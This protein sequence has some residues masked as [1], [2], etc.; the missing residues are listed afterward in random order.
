M[1]SSSAPCGADDSRPGQGQCRRRHHA[2]VLPCAVWPPL[3]P[4]TTGQRPALAA[5][6]PPGQADA[7]QHGRFPI[8]FRAPAKGTAWIRG[9]SIRGW[10][11]QCAGHEK[12]AAGSGPAAALVIALPCHSSRAFTI[13]RSWTSM[14]PADCFRNR[15]LSTKLCRAWEWALCACS[16]CCWLM[17]TSTMVRVPTS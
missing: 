12:A 14:T 6:T 1:T 13:S 16:S 4:D 7:A 3:R 5:P 8:L 9:A 17:S 2:G 15:L 11:R 10:H